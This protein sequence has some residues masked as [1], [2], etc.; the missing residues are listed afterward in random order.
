MK[1]GIIIGADIGGLM[2]APNGM[3]VFEKLGIVEDILNAGKTL[4]KISVVDFHNNLK[5]G[6]S[7]NAVQ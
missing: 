4:K 5:H 1:N 2:T 3:K 6:E 7:N